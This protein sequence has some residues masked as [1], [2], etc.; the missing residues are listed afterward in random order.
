MM[1]ILYILNT[2]V[3]SRTANDK[4]TI[5]PTSTDCALST[6]DG[7]LWVYVYEASSNDYCSQSQPNVADTP[8][9][10][11]DASFTC[12]GAAIASFADSPNFVL[13]V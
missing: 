6:C 2:V 3:V 8:I 5:T 11:A 13:V 10:Y 4:F 7:N 9:D 12:T 1:F